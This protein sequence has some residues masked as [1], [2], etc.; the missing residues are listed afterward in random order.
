MCVK[1]LILRKVCYTVDSSVDFTIDSV[2]DSTAGS[3]TVDST[4][5]SSVDSTVSRCPSEPMP[6]A[7]EYKEG[8]LGKQWVLGT[9]L[10]APPQAR[11]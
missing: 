8:A 7:P 6:T 9:L 2:V 10:R 4:I 1:L 3:T 11:L 5:D